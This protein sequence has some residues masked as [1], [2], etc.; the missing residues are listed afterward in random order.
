MMTSVVIAAIHLL[1]FEKSDLVFGLSTAI[2][3]MVVGSGDAALIIAFFIS[4]KL[5]AESF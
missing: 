3:S 2:I 5:F 4:L 1:V